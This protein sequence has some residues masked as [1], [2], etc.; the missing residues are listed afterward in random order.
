[1]LST[2]SLPLTAPLLTVDLDAIAANTR[3]FAAQATGDLIAVVK[4]DGYGHGAADV[5]RTALANGASMLGVTSVD[6]A[7]ALR[8]AG[9]TAPIISWLNHPATDFRRAVDERIDI[10]VPSIQHLDAVADVGG[11]ARVHLHLDTG[12]ARDGAE[13]MAWIELCLRAHQ[14]ERAGE[15]EVVGVMGHLGDADVPNSASNSLGLTLFEWGLDVARLAELRPSILHLAATSA[16]LTLPGSRFTASRVG[17][18]LVGID[19]SRTAPLAKPMTLTAPIISVR[20]VAVGTA[21]GYGHDWIAPRPTRLALVGLGY[22]DGLPRSSSGNAHVL[23]GGRRH[24]IVG[25]M[26]MDQFVIDLEDAN[27]TIGDTVTV[28]GP[29]TAG[30]PT[31]REWAEWSGTIEHEIVTRVG[32]RVRRTVASSITEHAA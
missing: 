25:R 2:A 26:S 15:I 29:G 24:P 21:V 11:R 20:K 5:A 1:M 7:L 9:F 4:A 28:F 32:A 14:A 16:T 6:E 31:V 10:A 23:L 13:P 19:L 8:D 3:F 27:A 12:L 18:G 30:E 17:A 22:A